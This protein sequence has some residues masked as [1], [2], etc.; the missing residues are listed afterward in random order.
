VNERPSFFASCL[1]ALHPPSFLASSHAAYSHHTPLMLPFP[2]H[3]MLIV[4]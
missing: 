3:A 4:P 2:V 1:P